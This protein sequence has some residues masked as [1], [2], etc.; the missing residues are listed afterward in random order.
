[1]MRNI[2]IASIAG[3]GALALALAGCGGSASGDKGEGDMGAEFITI[4]TGGSS[5]VYYQVG[6]TMSEML[7]AELGSDT[8]VQATG[9]SVENI[10]LLESG[11]VELAFAMGDAVTQATE[12]EGVF[13]GEEPKELQAIGSL[14]DQYLQLITLEGSGIESVEDLKGKRVSVGDL[15]SGL[16]L[17]TQMVVDAYGMS[18]DDFSADYLPYSEAIDGMRNQQ[19]DA[20]FVTSGL[21]NSAVTDLATT[22]DVN[23]IP[24]DGDGRDALLQQYD[25]LGEAQIPADVYEQEEDVESVTIPNVLLVSTDLSEDAVYDITS[26]LFGDLETLHNSHSAAKDIT[27]DNVTNGLTIDMH[28]GAQRFFEEEGAL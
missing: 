21:P 6:A 11:D 16:D 19:I 4:A 13:E 28:P 20:A 10:N 12:S 22:D 2:K 7:A 5:G 3:A 24:I 9:A 18:Y 26:T 8:S 27:L 23:L 1:M 15:N 25:F 17:N 14:Y